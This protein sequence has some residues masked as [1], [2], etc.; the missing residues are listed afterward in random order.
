[1]DL[2]HPRRCT[3]APHRH[4][5]LRGT[6]KKG[7]FQ[8]ILYHNIVN[9]EVHM[10]INIAIILTSLF[11]VSCAHWPWKKHPEDP[12]PPPS[13]VKTD[14][15]AGAADLAKSKNAVGTEASVIKTEASAIKVEADSGKKTFPSAPQW[16]LINRSAA[17]IGVSGDKLMEETKILGGI[18]VKLNTLK[19][20]V[21]ALNKTVKTFNEQLIVK[22]KI[23][24]EK[25]AKI[26]DFENGAKKRQQTIWMSIVAGCALAMAIG[27]FLAVYGVKELGV[28]LAVTGAVMS[29]VAYFMAA[30]A[31]IVAIIGGILLVLLII[32]LIRHIYVNRKA[33]TETVLA[34]EPVKTKE[35]DADTKKIVS[36]MQ[37]DTT[38]KL[39]NTIRVDAG[40][41]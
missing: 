15:G 37:S 23:I 29:C 18:E 6:K 2:N 9:S 7:L 30:Y 10:K 3:G 20:E 39:V 19:S 28:A 13:E 26:V 35:W 21:D 12:K 1:M 38:K 4:L 22:D 17:A 11:L 34:M 41:K 25:D 5:C 24:K 16:D 32:Y 14:I 36:S 8:S 31:F 33:L 27:I 40:V